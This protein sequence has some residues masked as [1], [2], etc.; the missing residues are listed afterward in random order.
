MESPIDRAS[1]L[2]LGRPDL[3]PL[4]PLREP[5]VVPGLTPATAPLPRRNIP[6]QILISHK[7]LSSLLESLF[8][9]SIPFAVKSASA[10]PAGPEMSMRVGPAAGRDARLL[11][12]ATGCASSC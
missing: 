7:T 9:C 11:W 6:P 2:L 5:V 10:R 3:W 1:G 4:L 12:L 8:P